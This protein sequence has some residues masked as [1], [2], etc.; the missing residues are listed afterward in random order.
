[1]KKTK[2]FYEIIAKKRLSE[3]LDSV[4]RHMRSHLKNW[5]DTDKD[6]YDE[7]IQRNINY[8]E[9]VVALC[10]DAFTCYLD[11]LRRGGISQEIIESID[12][13]EKE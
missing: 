6:L 7:S 2:D 8:L 9:S 5:L 13:N 1:M 11:N 10:D 4:S 12:K 3:E